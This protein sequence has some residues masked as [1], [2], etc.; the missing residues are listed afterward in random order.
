[1]NCLEL[2]ELPCIYC[3]EGQIGIDDQLPRNELIRKRR[4][5]LGFTANELAD[6]VGYY[7]MS[8]EAIDVNAD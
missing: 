3:K 5:E 4:E 1:M 6:Q 8:I 7:G 2:F